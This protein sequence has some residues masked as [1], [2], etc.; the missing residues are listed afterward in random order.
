MIK[1][2][3]IQIMLCKLKCAYHIVFMIILLLI[4]RNAQMCGC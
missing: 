3:N 2:C 4:I 1:A